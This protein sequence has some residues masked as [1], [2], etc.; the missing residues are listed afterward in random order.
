MG[1]GSHLASLFIL[2]ESSLGPENLGIKS[3]T[4]GKDITLIIRTNNEGMDI[5]CHN[6][7]LSYLRFRGSLW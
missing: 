1:Q 6:V 5:G 2:S 3:V 7:S 4:E